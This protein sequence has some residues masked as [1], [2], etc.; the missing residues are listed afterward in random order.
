[1]CIT[2]IMYERD[3]LVH[4]YYNNIFR[5]LNF[6]NVIILIDIQIV[7]HIIER[8]DYESVSLALYSIYIYGIL[9]TNVNVC[10]LQ[11]YVQN[12]CI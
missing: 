11:V 3:K 2:R 6:R 4:G 5:I 1:M 9:N 10:L 12:V 8:I 7:S